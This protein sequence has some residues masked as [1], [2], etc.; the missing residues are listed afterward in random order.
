MEKV[1]N[2]KRSKFT[3]YN[4]EDEISIRGEERNAP[5]K[6]KKKRGGGIRF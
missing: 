1:H 2:E 3:M 5:A 6:K 4:F